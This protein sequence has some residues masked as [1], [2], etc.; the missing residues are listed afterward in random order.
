[1]LYGLTNSHTEFVFALHIMI[2]ITK[3]SK[4]NQIHLKFVNSSLKIANRYRNTS[5]FKNKTHNNSKRSDLLH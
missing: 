2:M 3:S 1:M 4:R 5:I